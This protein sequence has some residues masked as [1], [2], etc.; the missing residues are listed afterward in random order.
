MAENDTPESTQTPEETT[1]ENTQEAAPVVKKVASKKKVAKK[2]VAKKKA[3]KKKTA[4]KK[5][6]K[7]KVAKK[8]TAKK[9]AA[10]AP[11][12]ASATESRSSGQEKAREELQKM[13]MMPKSD[14]K[15][16]SAPDTVKAVSRPHS[17]W[18]KTII[19]VVIVILLYIWIRSMAHDVRQVEST[20]TDS[21]V[22]TPVSPADSAPVKTGQL[23][24]MPMSERA[25]MGVIKEAEIEIVVIEAKPPVQKAPV[26]APLTSA[27]T[28]AANPAANAPQAAQPAQHP[29]MTATAAGYSPYD[30]PQPG[31]APA[32]P[33]MARPAA[34]PAAA[35]K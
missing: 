23:P 18:P 1:A 20:S 25:N 33:W 28:A 11:A 24:V 32:P 6:T 8:K 12:A 29:G 14:T 15:A 10:V 3:S 34:A 9:K 7:K 27:K 31:Y 35:S 19:W 30:Y 4:K 26:S 5:A 21:A 22:T 16:A 2:K 13:G 17:F